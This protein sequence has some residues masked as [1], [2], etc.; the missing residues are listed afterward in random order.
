MFDLLSSKEKL[1]S[2]YG[3]LFFWIDYESL[4]LSFYLV[5]GNSFLSVRLCLI[6]ML[7]AF[8]VASSGHTSAI[9]SIFSLAGKTV[10]V[11]E[12]W[13]AYVLFLEINPLNSLHFPP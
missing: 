4:V 8:F 5:Q 1:H 2:L 3:V 10:W 13:Q 7:V 6:S 9:C 11:E 12:L